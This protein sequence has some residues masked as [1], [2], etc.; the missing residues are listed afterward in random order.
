MAHPLVVENLRKV[1]VPRRSLFS[2]VTGHKKEPFV[3]VDSISFS[4]HEGEILGFLGPNG[5]G[6][7]TT[8]N[9]LL[10]L[11]TPTKGT[12]C[13]FGQTLDSRKRI[14]PYVAYASG[15]MKLPATLTVRESLRMYGLLYNMPWRYMTKKIDEIIHAFALESLENRMVTTLSAGQTTSVL[16]ARV[17]LVEPRIILL[18]EPTSALDPES[19]NRVRSFIAEQNRKHKISILF[20]SHN[21][22]EVAE[23]CHRILMLKQGRIIA[24][25]TPESLARSVSVARLSFVFTQGQ[26]IAVRYAHEHSLQCTVHEHSFELLV[27]EHGIAQ[28]LADFAGLGILYS[29]ISIEKPSL[30]DYFLSVATSK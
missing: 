16:L 18:D 17:F 11:L 30:E 3:A 9:M 5:A 4:L 29:Q 22:P 15:F 28:L 2:R 27:H 20:T 21:M 1:F 26:E 13:Y 6:K 19:A 7:T 25:N 23:L 24:D 10:N 12:I 8:I 14:P